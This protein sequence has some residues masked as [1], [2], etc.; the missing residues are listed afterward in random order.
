MAH[1][2]GES[3]GH[4]PGSGASTKRDDK[5]RE[6]L[7]LSGDDPPEPLGAMTTIGSG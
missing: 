4:R 6:A 2:D 7:M 5:H 1:H 3:Q